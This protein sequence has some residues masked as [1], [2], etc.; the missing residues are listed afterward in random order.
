MEAV[1]G[2]NPLVQQALAV[3]A[4]G[5]LEPEQTRTGLTR[6]RDLMAT[7]HHNRIKRLASAGFT[8]A[9]AQ[10]LSAL[11]T[12]NFMEATSFGAC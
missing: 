5:G 3:L 6:V 9:M 4:S 8:D 1:I 12:P 11:P 10:E 2:I 7:M